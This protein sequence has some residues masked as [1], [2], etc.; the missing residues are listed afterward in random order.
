VGKKTHRPTIVESIYIV[1]TFDMKTKVQKW[2]NSLGVRLPK[3]ITDELGL[4][5]DRPV[6]MTYKDK[7]IIIE[8]I[9]DSENLADLVERISEDNR[10]QET[11][12]FAEQGKE[13]W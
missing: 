5:A 9:A 4:S 3:N 6:K 13:V 7:K 12:W 11:D 8:M 1:Y 2:G 10:H